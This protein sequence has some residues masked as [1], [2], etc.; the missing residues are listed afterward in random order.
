MTISNCLENENEYVSPE[1]AN[2]VVRNNQTLSLKKYPQFTGQDNFVPEKYN[3]R[4][5]INLLEEKH[6]RGMVFFYFDDRADFISLCS[7]GQL[8]VR[9]CKDSLF[10][11]WGNSEFR[12]IKPNSIF[13]TLEDKVIKVNFVP[14][15]GS[16]DVLFN[17][18]GKFIRW[19]EDPSTI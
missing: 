11:F 3:P 17:S 1:H 19:L 8:N 12:N 9:G 14:F 16:R 13:Q 7:D 18:F 5:I 15:S 2:E 10:I 4:A 6:L